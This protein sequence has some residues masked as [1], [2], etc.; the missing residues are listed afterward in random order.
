VQEGREEVVKAGRVRWQER[1][2]V[3]GQEPWWER[4]GEACPETR[5]A[6]IEMACWRQPAVA[7]G[8][9]AAAVQPIACRPPARR[10]VGSNQPVHVLNHLG[11]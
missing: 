2:E 9:P 10:E 7:F 1:N 11:A 8:C 4:A 3:N 5:K 6:R